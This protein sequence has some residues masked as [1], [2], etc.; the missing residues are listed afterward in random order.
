MVRTIHTNV[1]ENQK[2]I[3][4]ESVCDWCGSP[5]GDLLFSGPDLLMDLPG[6]FRLVRCPTCGLVRQNPWLAWESLKSYY[7]EDYTAY[8][9]IIDR[10]R[11]RLRRA[12]RRYG[13][14]KRLRS[15]ERFQP[16]GKLLD[17]GC[18]TGIF[19]AEAQRAG[20]W[21]LTGVEPSLAAS[22]YVQNELNIPVFNGRFADAGLPAGHFDVIT[23]WNVLEH[24]DHP[25]GDLRR[26]AD[27]LRPGGWLVFSIPNLESIEASLFGRHWLGWDLPRHLYLFPQHQLR[28]ILQETGLRLVDRQNIA[29]SHAALEYSLRFLFNARGWRGQ[30]AQTLLRIYRSL[31]SR[32]LAAPVFWTIDQLKRGSLITIFAQKGV[33]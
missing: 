25:V 12:D 4:E 2:L 8:E 24:L 14:W 1:E 10:E 11:S 9:P 18:G 26:A 29:G 7:P 20:H 22:Q 27:L 13:M 23:L 15:I 32:V 21:E 31:P 5:G 6:E 19:L 16:G 33:V 28:S 30:K 17:V 3:W